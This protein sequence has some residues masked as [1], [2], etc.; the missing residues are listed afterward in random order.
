[1]PVDDL[2]TP[3]DAGVVARVAGAVGT[4]GADGVDVAVRSLRW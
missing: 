3:V 2:G 1:M 4:L